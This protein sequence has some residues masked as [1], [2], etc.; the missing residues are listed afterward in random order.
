M[1]DFETIGIAD[2]FWELLTS[3]KKR[4]S[5]FVIQVR[6]PS[7]VALERVFSRDQTHQIQLEKEVIARMNEQSLQMKFECDL[8][9]E[10]EQAT[11]EQLIQQLNIIW[12]PSR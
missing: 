8:I 1:V 4:Y 9:L 2:A 3:L 10:N 12:T 7:H 11:D 5:V 6:V